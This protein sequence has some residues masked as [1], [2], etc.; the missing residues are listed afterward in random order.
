MSTRQ[1]SKFKLRV[2]CAACS[3]WMR[4]TSRSENCKNFKCPICHSWTIL[5]E[6]ALKFMKEKQQPIK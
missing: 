6:V 4:A 2:D 1:S 5:S 3:V